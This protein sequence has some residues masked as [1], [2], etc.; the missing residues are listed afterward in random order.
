MQQSWKSSDSDFRHK[1]EHVRRLL[2]GE[3][4][5]NHQNSIRKSGWQSKEFWFTH[6]DAITI[7]EDWNLDNSEK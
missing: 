4:G 5:I 1:R 3:R 7:V 2:A 6:L